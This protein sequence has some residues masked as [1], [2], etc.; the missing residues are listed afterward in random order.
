[1]GAI[2]GALL[3]SRL[4]GFLENP[5][6]NAFHN[7]ISLLNNKSI[8]GGLFGGLLGVEISKKI[9]HEKNS[10]GDLFTFPIIIGIIIGRFGCF[11]TGIKEFTYGKETHFFTG[12]NLGDGVLRHP[13]ALYEIIFLIF[14]FVFLKKNSIFALKNHG[15]IFI[16]F[17]LSYFSFRFFIEFLKPNTYFI[18]GLSSIQILCIICWFYYIP[19]ILKKVKYAY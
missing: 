15:F 11:L 9:I 6:I 18:A 2:L 14:L 1:L 12:I 19:I 10:S 5:E 8:M 16:A 3:G 4:M 17:M 7:L 13:I